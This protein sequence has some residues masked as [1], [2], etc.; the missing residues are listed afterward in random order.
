[1]AFDI[2]YTELLFKMNSEHITP[3]T[4]ITKQCRGERDVLA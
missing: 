4:E 2:I 3:I 1:M